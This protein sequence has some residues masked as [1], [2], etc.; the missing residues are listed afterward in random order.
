MKAYRGY[1][2]P[3]RDS[4]NDLDC[5]Q[6]GG[7]FPSFT[8]LAD[9]VTTIHAVTDVRDMRLTGRQIMD[10]QEHE[11]LTQHNKERDDMAQLPRSTRLADARTP[12]ASIGRIPGVSREESNNYNPF[13]KAAHIGH[14]GA[15]AKLTLTGNVRMSDGQ[16]GEQIIVEVRLGRVT[17]DLAIKLNSP[18]HREL[19]DALGLQT[20]RWKNKSIAVEVKEHM[21]LDYIAIQ[22]ARV[23]GGNSR[24]TKKTKRAKR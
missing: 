23:Q 18:N 7:W 12:K 21:G 6:C 19:E 9:H 24:K 13:L 4:I 8:A 22:R 3:T 10:Q 14:V 2:A 11:T 5:P 17:Y 20:A 15:T 1:G 16:F